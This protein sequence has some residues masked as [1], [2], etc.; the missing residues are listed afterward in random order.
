MTEPKLTKGGRMPAPVDVDEAI[1]LVAEEGSSTYSPSNIPEFQP[2]VQL[3]FSMP[4][5]AL[6]ACGLV[7]DT[8]LTE[9]GGRW[10]RTSGIGGLLSVKS[11]VDGIFTET[12]VEITTA[13]G[14]VELLDKRRRRNSHNYDE[15]SES[16]DDDDGY[17]EVDEHDREEDHDQN[18]GSL[19]RQTAILP[20]ARIADRRYLHVSLPP[21]EIAEPVAALGDS[22]KQVRC[23]IEVDLVFP[24]KFGNDLWHDL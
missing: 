22:F 18:D 16:D 9:P 10:A 12:I 21:E 5:D 17:D 7:F 23:Q 8:I 15:G 24:M 2:F 4:T 14:L 11:E 1:R 19:L 6:S 3:R 13:R 20:A